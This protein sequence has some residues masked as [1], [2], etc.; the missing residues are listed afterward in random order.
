LFFSNIQALGT[1]YNDIVFKGGGNV[2]IG[3]G[4]LFYSQQYKLSVIGNV[5][6]SNLYVDSLVD[7][8]NVNVRGS[9]TCSDSFLGDMYIYGNVFSSGNLYVS[10][11]IYSENFT[12]TLG[13]ALSDEVARLTYF[14]TTTLRS[15]Y[16]FKIL[17]SNKP[18]FWLNNLPTSTTPVEFD[19]L[20]NGTSIYTGDKP[21]IAS[22][23]T[24]YSTNESQGTLTG[25][26]ITVGK[27]SNIYVKINNIGSGNPFGAK[28]VIYAF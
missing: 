19:I 25:S 18:L 16:S 20:I 6:A 26:P 3:N 13:G 22:T 15:P 24:T 17:N 9:L 8:N 7:T 11:N 12:R 27:F 10:G 14:N 2:V 23:S 28:F 4:G 1:T 5:F 21:K